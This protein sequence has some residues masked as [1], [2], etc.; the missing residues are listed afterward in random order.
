MVIEYG[1]APRFKRIRSQLN[2][3]LFGTTPAAPSNTVIVDQG[4]YRNEVQEFLREDSTPPPTEP[5]TASD[6]NK[7][8]TSPAPAELGASTGPN[9]TPLLPHLGHHV[10]TSITLQESHT[11]STSSQTISI[12]ALPS[13]PEAEVNPPV[14]QPK[15]S[16]PAARKK[17]VNTDGVDTSDATNT[18]S[19]P[20]T[21]GTRAS[22]RKASSP[23][24]QGSQPTARGSGRKRT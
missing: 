4:D 13:E 6:I 9:P 11:V 19:A 22:A 3:L 10:T 17:V 1:D 8:P 14:V 15:K 18:T 16:R 12:T 23:P 24:N 21:R 5:S 7:T 2:A 20:T